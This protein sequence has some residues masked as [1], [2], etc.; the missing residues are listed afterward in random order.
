MN[1]L[2]RYVLTLFKSYSDILKRRFSNDFNKVFISDEGAD[3][4]QIIQEDNYMPMS[5]EKSED[6][7]QIQKVTLFGL[8]IDIQSFPQNLPFSQL[9]PLC[10]NNI[11]NF[12]TEYYM[13]SD[14]Y[15]YSQHDVD[16]ILRR[17]CSSY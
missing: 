16:E 14:E 7:E 13:F 3:V 2:D 9:Y 17:V 5:V 12:V 10:C 8:D 4:V 6:L 15:I 1:Q 11:R